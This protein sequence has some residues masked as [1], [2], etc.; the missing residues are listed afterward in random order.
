VLPY[1]NE[2]VSFDGQSSHKL[3]VLIQTIALS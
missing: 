3:T 1:N 2:N